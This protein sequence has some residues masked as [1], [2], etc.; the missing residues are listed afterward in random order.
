MLDDPAAWV[1]GGEAILVD[2]EPVG[3]LSSAGWSLAAGRCIG[4]GYVR[5][6]S[7][8]RVHAGTPVQVD[9]WGRAITATAWDEAV[10]RLVA[11]RA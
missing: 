11:N 3:E 6:A 7:A 5:G 1:W 2:G 10:G 4:L 9:L 8:Q